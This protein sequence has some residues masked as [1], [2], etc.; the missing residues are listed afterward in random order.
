MAVRIPWIALAGVLA[1][2]G[3]LL[4]DAAVRLHP[5]LAIPCPFKAFTGIPCA[6]CG[7]TRCVLALAAGRWAEAFHWHPVAGVL[8]ALFPLA[9]AW[10]LG[11]AWRGSPYPPLPDHWAPRLL[12]G[13]ALLG[14]WALQILRGM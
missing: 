9:M 6:T 7:L 8:L 14:S 2:V 10:D 3:A 11:R 4:L 13:T 12:V 1:G 5:A